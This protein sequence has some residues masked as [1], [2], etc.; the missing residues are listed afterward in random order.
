MRSRPLGYPPRLQEDPAK[1][2]NLND[3]LINK[4]SRLRRQ[5]FRPSRSMPRKGAR[6]AGR[7][8]E[9]DMAALA[10]HH[11][12]VAAAHTRAQSMDP[13]QTRGLA[14][15]GKCETIVADVDAPFSHQ[16]RNRLATAFR[17]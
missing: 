10:G 6:V 13:G 7:R 8:Y 9:L 16:V 3:A 17:R 2:R 1:R 5:I 12:G 11:S 14:S 15:E 4:R